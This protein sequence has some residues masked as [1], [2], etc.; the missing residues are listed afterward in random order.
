MAYFAAA[1]INESQFVI[2]E[3]T[4]NDKPAGKPASSPCMA[5]GIAHSLIYT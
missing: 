3:Q 5:S 4:G 1:E 2:H